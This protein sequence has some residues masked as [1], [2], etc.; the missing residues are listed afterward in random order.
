MERMRQTI[1]VV[2]LS[3]LM[4]AMPGACAAERGALFKVSGHGHTMYLFGTMHV[5]M[6]DFYPL[7]ARIR[8]AVENASTLALEID[9]LAEP[10]RM[11]AAL[12]TYGAYD[13][14]KS[15][16][17]EMPP[18]LR[19]RLDKV[20]RERSIDPF[21]VAHLKPWLVATALTMSEFTLQ[22]CRPELSV[23]LHLAQMARERNVPLVELESL[24]IQLSLFD[25]LSHADQWRYLESTVEGIENGRQRAEVKQV[26]DAWSKADRTALDA[27]AERAEKDTTVAG[28][29]VQKVL[30]EERNGPMAD[31]LARLLEREDKAV[32]AIGVLHLIGKGSVPARLRAKGMTVERVY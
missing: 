31:K 14:R 29:F 25:R 8:T 24:S 13:P 1:I 32:A 12:Q 16:G 27:I 7:E 18:S 6:P 9:P 26:I 5:G 11:A 23:D 3:W 17:R 2:F 10:A 21:T 30:L 15:A 19:P 20:L 4:L 22:G 28:K